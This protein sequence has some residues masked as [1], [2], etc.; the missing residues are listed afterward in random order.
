MSRLSVATQTCRAFEPSRSFCDA[1]G[2]GRQNR[3]LRESVLEAAGVWCW[4]YGVA[5]AQ[6]FVTLSLQLKAL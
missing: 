6:G 4:G 1:R 3:S 2:H 5:G